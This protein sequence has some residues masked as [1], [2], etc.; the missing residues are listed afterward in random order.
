M[1]ISLSP[2]QSDEGPLV[3]AA[4]RD[5]T[6]RRNV[7]RELRRGQRAAPSRRQHGRTN[8]EIAS[9][10]PVR[11]HSRRRRRMALRTVRPTRRRQLQ[12]LRG[13]RPARGLLHARRDGTRH[14]D[15]PAV[16]RP[17]ADTREHLA[18]TEQPHAGQARGAAQHGVPESTWTPGSTFTFLGGVLDLSKGALQVRQR[19]VI[20]A[21]STCRPGV[22]PS[23]WKPQVCPSGCS[24]MPSTR[25]SQEQLA[26][27]DRLY[28]FSD[29]GDRGH[30]RGRGGLRGRE[31]GRR[32]GG[33]RSA[34]AGRDVAAGTPFGRPLVRRRVAP[35]RLH[36]AGAGG[37]GE[38]RSRHP[39]LDRR[40]FLS[41]A[42]AALGAA[43][44]HALACRHAGALRPDGAVPLRGRPRRVD[45]GP[46]RDHGP[47]AAASPRRL[48]LPVVRLDRRPAR[49]RISHAGPARRHGGVPGR[50]Q[51]G[52]ARAQPRDPDRRRVRRAPRSTTRTAAAARRQS[53]SIR[54]PARRAARG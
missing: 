32:T 13:S 51:P 6:E 10:G 21:R 20:T 42:G 47:P 24:P 11:R 16:G 27:G 48:P 50:R 54:R 15:G 9:A 53:S 36:A 12:R 22:R 52:A 41:L 37:S 7:E 38:V 8:P 2:I 44:F 49:R 30:E 25:N 14:R 4:I 17:D 3:I 19:R 29:G 5:M 35:G 31:A 46:R 28:L 1:D 43:P 23:P 40:A 18:A 45:A 34:A 39:R 26:P 33:S